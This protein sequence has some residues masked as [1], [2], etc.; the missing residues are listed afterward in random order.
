MTLAA[1][2]VPRVLGVLV[3]EVLEVE[4]EPVAVNAAVVPIGAVAAA[5]AVAAVD[6]A[7]TVAGVA[8]LG[9]EVEHPRVVEGQSAVQLQG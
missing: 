8:V 2:E 1:V 6:V 9:E 5:V 3:C 7:A 4:V